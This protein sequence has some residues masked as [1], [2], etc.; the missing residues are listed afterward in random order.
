M[1]NIKT[2]LIELVNIYQPKFITTWAQGDSPGIAPRGMVPAVN[3]DAI[4][5][6]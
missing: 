1:I 6:T 3:F 4:L 2:E 5:G